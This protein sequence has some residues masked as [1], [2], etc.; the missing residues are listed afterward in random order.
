[1][2]RVRESST[3]TCPPPNAAAYSA[4]A[5]D[6][7]TTGMR[8]QKAWRGALWV[9]VGKKGVIGGGGRLGQGTVCL[10]DFVFDFLG[11]G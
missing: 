7:T 6:A 5:T 2:V 1:M 4:S 8:W 3:N 10:F 9:E 11:V